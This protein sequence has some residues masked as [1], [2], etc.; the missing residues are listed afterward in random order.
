MYSLNGSDINAVLLALFTDDEI[1]MLAKVRYLY[2]LGCSCY[3]EDTIEYKRLI[4]LE[5]LYQGGWING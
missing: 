4:F 2:R 3:S 1:V 5:Y